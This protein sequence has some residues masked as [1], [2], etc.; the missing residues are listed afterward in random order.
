MDPISKACKSVSKSEITIQIID[1]ARK[2]V[3]TN[4]AM[5]FYIFS[6][7]CRNEYEK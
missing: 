1:I 6:S 7:F 3:P 2:N 4:S 5:Y